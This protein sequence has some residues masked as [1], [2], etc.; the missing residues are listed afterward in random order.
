MYLDFTLCYMELWDN[1]ENMTNR[2]GSHQTTP[3]LFAYT[4]NV[5]K[6]RTL[7]SIHFCLNFAFHAVIS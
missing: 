6:F 3:L 2:E 1:V 7:Y 5:L 4:V